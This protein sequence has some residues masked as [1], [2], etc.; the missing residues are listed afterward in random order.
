MEYA[1]KRGEVC[2]TRINESLMSKQSAGYGTNNLVQ[3]DFKELAGQ[4]K[5]DMN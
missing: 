1:L 5:Q 3:N 4:L 2:K